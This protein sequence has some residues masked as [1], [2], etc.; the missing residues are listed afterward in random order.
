MGLLDDETF[1][2]YQT[3]RS[4]YQGLKHG[5]YQFVSLEDIINQFMVVYVGEEKVISNVKRVDVAFHAQRALREL[6]FDTFKSVKSFEIELPPSLTM[7]LPQDYVNYTQISWSDGNGIKRPLYP[8]SLT[9][10]PFKIQQESDGSYEFTP[11]WE[12]LQNNDFATGD[13]SSWSKTNQSSYNPPNAGSS[14][15]IFVDNER[16]AFQSVPT[17][18]NVV[19]NPATTP[20]KANGV[21][22]IILAI[23]QPIDVR[24]VQELN[25]SATG[26]SAAGIY[27]SA[28]SGTLSDAGRLWFGVSSTEPTPYTNPDPNHA[29]PSFN[30]NPPDLGNIEWYDGDDVAS[31]KSMDVDVS[32]YETVW[33]IVSSYTQFRDLT[34]DA[35]TDTMLGFSNKTLNNG[36][37]K[38]NHFYDGNY[39][40][41]Y[42]GE[43][44]VTSESNEELI[45]SE[46]TTWTKYSNDTTAATND[47]FAY[48]HD[49]DIYDLNIGQRYGMDP[50][51]S[52]A[53]G[54]FF[55]DEVRGLI[56]FSSNIN[57][58][59][60]ILDYISDSLGTD[61]EMQV[62]KF[63]EDAMYK[64]ITHAVLSTRFNT[65]EYVIQRWKKEKF[66]AT[67][68]AKL[69]LSNIKPREI[70]QILRGKSKRIKH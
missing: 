59:N 52:Q 44:S 37:I 8:T 13:I 9:S 68:Q 64:W 58:K 70:T 42:I 10:N 34:Y 7:I 19:T 5:T 12:L 56:N 51:L 4:Y 18:Q 49:T 43:I 31:E 30:I 35:T 57:G 32:N 26:E 20:G 47:A 69:R 33:V 22:G 67:R 16:A 46:S 23:W 2:N 3:P 14:N 41:N 40:T 66:A 55:I 60:V 38:Y 1:T 61:E 45:L 50:A 36:T 17:L 11:N 54:S 6:S 27:N 39:A 28:S 15:R 63:A 65:P 53:N 21:D 29:K 24:N 25:M 62:H 48:N